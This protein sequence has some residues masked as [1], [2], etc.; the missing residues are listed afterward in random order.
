MLCMAVSYR[1]T[2]DITAHRM[3]SCLITTNFLVIETVLITSVI[4]LPLCFYDRVTKC[5]SLLHVKHYKF[6]R[7]ATF[8][9][10]SIFYRGFKSIRM[11][12]EHWD[13]RVLVLPRFG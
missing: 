11:Y 1:I 13:P 6:V 2:P 8:S 3:F 9:I 12:L 10:H 5:M 7:D 4:F